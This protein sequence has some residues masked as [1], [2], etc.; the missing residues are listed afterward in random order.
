VS[1]EGW[2]QTDS[3]ALPTDATAQGAH[4]LRL[5]DLSVWNGTSLEPATSWLVPAGGYVVFSSKKGL[6]GEGDEVKV[7][8][9]DGTQLIDQKAYGN[10]E[11]GISDNNDLGAASYAANPDGGDTFMSVTFQTFAFSNAAAITAGPPTPTNVKINELSAAAGKVEVKNFGAAAVDLSG[12]TLDTGSTAHTVPAG[13]SLPAGGLY[14]AD[15]VTLP[16]PGSVKLR[17]AHGA[18]SDEF[19]WI[20]DGNASYSRCVFGASAVLVETPTATFNAENACPVFDPAPWPGSQDVTIVDESNT[21][22]DGDGNGEGDVSGVTFDPTDPTILWAVQN[23][24]T[25]FKLRKNAATGKYD[26]VPG[27]NLGKKLHFAD[28]TGQP[29]SEGVTVGPDGAV[30]VTSERDNA[31]KGV[32]Y[33]KVL[34]FD[35]SGDLSGAT[36]LTATHEWDVNSIVTT[37]TNLGLEGITWVPDEALTAGGFRNEAGAAYAPNAYPGHGS[38]LFVVAVEGTGDLH[39]FALPRDGSTSG[40]PQLVRTIK[41]GFPWS[42]DVAWDADRKMLWALCDDGCGGTYNTLQLTDGAFEVVGSYS[43]PAAM[44]NLNNEGMAIA[45]LSTAS[46]ETVEVVWADDGDTDGHSL[47]GGRLWSTTDL[48]D[49]SLVPHP[50]TASVTFTHDQ[51]TYGTAATVVVSVDAPES[52]VTGSAQLFAG[53]TAI[54][55]PADVVAGTAT[56][57]VPQAGLAPG[58]HDLTVAFTS[59]DTRLVRDAVSPAARVTVAKGNVAKVGWRL[60]KR[61]TAQKAGTV[62]VTVGTPTGLAKATGRATLVIKKGSRTVRTITVRTVKNGTASLT[63]P[64]LKAG[65]YRVRVTWLG[66]S[67]YVAKAG[68]FK[69]LVVGK[70]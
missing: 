5:T 44:P 70:K 37:G 20:E 61:P 66:S 14:V 45:P 68:G 8:S 47:R 15:G 58:Q 1:V 59:A 7:Y 64:R 31:L 9:P 67:H 32:S 56:V 2:L 42:M 53:T 23:K 35:V 12:W 48:S 55:A 63:L 26:D 69:R 40:T 38:G 19:S 11:A 28:G 4:R 50:A 33:N 22:G 43:R 30:Y 27:W 57:T 41:S 3:G 62:V 60:T 6:S 65:K 49:P 25:L 29:D 10:G 39:A 16:V 36:D 52:V 46:G 34:R 24:N 17:K 54:G 18:Q 13:T 51:L 21:F